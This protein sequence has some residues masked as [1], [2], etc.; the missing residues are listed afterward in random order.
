MIYT[1]KKYD[2]QY[3]ENWSL[4]NEDI[5]VMWMRLNLKLTRPTLLANIYR[6]PSGSITSF[7]E[8]LEQK[9]MDI[10]TQMDGQ[11]D[12]LL[13]GDININLN[14]IRDSHVNQYRDFLKCA[15]LH[16]LNKAPTRVPKTSSQT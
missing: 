12:L 8:I 3:L 10:A 2:F 13:V 6:P 14:S 1:D 7:K 4:G 11:Y 5:E 9:L 16:S 15:Q